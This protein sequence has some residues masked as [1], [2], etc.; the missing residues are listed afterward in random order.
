MKVLSKNIARDMS[1][2]GRLRR[3]LEVLASNDGSAEEPKRM[4]LGDQAT[5]PFAA[6]LYR[7]WSKEDFFERL[8]TYGPG[9][10]AV[11][12]TI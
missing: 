9:E 8:Q 11:P 3:A 7:P 5:G 2:D 1:F 6:P 12:V 4:R 10:T